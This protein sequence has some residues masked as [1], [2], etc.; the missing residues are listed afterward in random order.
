MALNTEQKKKLA[1]LAEELDLEDFK[2][3]YDFLRGKINVLRQI[4]ENTASKQFSHGDRVSFPTKKGRE[5]GEVIGIN[6][7]SAKV[8][9]DKDGREWLVSHSLLRKEPTDGRSQE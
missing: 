5:K 3:V 6:S 8:K 7:M 1:E 9:A 4:K 2:E